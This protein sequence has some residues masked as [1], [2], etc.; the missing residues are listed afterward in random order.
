MES[1]KEAFGKWGIKKT[2]VEELTRMA[3][4]SKGAFY[5]FFQSK[6]DLYF[7]IIR[8]FENKVHSSIL[9]LLSEPSEDDQL[10]F[11]KVLKQIF[12][13]IDQEPFIQ[14]LLAKEEMNYLWQRF[15]EEQLT[16]SMEAD[17]DFSSQLVSIWQKKGKLK[18]EDPAVITGLFRGIFFMFL[19]KEEI[20]VN[21]F[22]QV[23]DLL[24]E[25]SVSRVIDK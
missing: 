2:S 20:G 6:E 4:I 22:Y 12:Q 13:Q 21:V 8:N 24:I 3:G 15:S 10:L 17:L 14:N 19:H 9:S 1:G 16:E 7:N 5:K 23:M 25:A 18:I 11:M